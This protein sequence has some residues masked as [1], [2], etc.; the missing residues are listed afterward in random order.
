MAKS[1]KILAFHT[2]RPVATRAASGWHLN[3]SRKSDDDINDPTNNR[4]P[5]RRNRVQKNHLKIAAKGGIERT[6]E[7]YCDLYLHAPAAD[8]VLAGEGVIIEASLAAAGLLGVSRHGLLGQPM[9][10]FVAKRDAIGFRRHGRQVL[11]TGSRWTCEIALVQTGGTRFPARLESFALPRQ[12]G[13]SELWRMVVTDLTNDQTVPGGGARCE[14]VESRTDIDTAHPERSHQD[15]AANLRLAEEALLEREAF[16]RSLIGRTPDAIITIDKNGTIEFFCHSA[17]RLFGYSASEVLGQKFSMLLPESH[18]QTYDRFL[19]QKLK[20]VGKPQVGTDRVVLGRR[21]DA[22]TFLMEIV[23]AEFVVN[24]KRRFT[25][26]AR[27]ITNSRQ[28]NRR[29]QDLQADYL[30]ASS[31]TTTLETASTLAHELLQPLTAIMN[32][33][34]A[35]RRMVEVSNCQASDEVYGWMDKSINEARRAGQIVHN[36]KGLIERGESERSE[37]NINEIVKETTGISLARAAK[38]KVQLHLN[39]GSNLPPV[40]ADKNQIQQVIL[41]LFQNAIDVLVEAEQKT[42]SIKTALAAP[43]FVEVTIS[44]SGQGLSPEVAK[45]LFQPIV[46]RKE[47]GMGIGLSICRSIIDVHCGKIWAAPNEGCGASFHFTL[48]IVQ[49]SSEGHE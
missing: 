43:D 9:S 47:E 13:A 33:V 26:I 27:D 30:W 14:K 32:Y 7:W 6:R 23:I 16:I 37:E 2:Q 44:D 34:K 39:L 18:H 31:R 15:S 46:S 41:N 22:S 36:L 19:M 21:K 1:R 29:M 28:A 12:E 4:L 20:A 38:E 48:P 25:T 35:S 8:F 5:Q 10:R 40:L 3:D 17:E 49:K 42:L 45:R 24:G 11:R